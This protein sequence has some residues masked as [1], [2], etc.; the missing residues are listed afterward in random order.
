MTYNAFDFKLLAAQGLARA[1]NKAVY[2]LKL[3]DRYVCADFDSWLTKSVPVSAF[4]ALVNPCG[5]IEFFK[6]P[7][8]YIK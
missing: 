8:E 6:D 7:V 1:K 5:A 4:K 3:A 2:V